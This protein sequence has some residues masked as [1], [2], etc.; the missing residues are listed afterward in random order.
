MNTT[1]VVRRIDELGRIVIPKEI[2]RSLGIKVGT[3]L[4]IMVNDGLISLRK[5]SS[6]N[7]LSNFAELY[8]DSVYKVTKQII[9]ITDRDTIVAVSN[10]LKKKYLNKPISIFLENSLKSGK[11]VVEST[12]QN[13][14]LVNGD[15]E[16]SSYI[17]ENI[18]SNGDSIGL[19]IMLSNNQR[20]T[21]E[22]EQTIEI[23]AQI[24]G[25]RI[26]D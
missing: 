20:I 14:S 21:V 4:E 1:G 19:V 2:R 18:I 3:S 10:P 25:K 5:Q 13:I 6:M 22:D 12:P 17:I 7:N 15:T 9:V 26:E 8:A 16:E 24:L 11:R 23:A